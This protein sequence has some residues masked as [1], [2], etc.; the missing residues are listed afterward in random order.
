MHR[1]TLNIYCLECSEMFRWRKE[2]LIRGD[3]AYD[4]RIVVLCGCG[5]SADPD[6]AA[7][8]RAAYDSASVDDVFNLQEAAMEKVIGEELQ[9]ALNDLAF[10]PPD[11][12]DRP[13]HR[14]A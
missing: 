11:A 4:W 2:H 1:G 5:E 10:P 9:T 7:A 14:R 3:G 12:G 8:A 13:A 6:L